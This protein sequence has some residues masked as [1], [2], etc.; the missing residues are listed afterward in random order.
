MPKIK[1]KGILT[2]RLKITKNGKILRRQGFRRHLKASK[3]SKRLH[4]LKKTIEL[5]G[6]YAK[7]I[8]KSTGTK[9]K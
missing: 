5:I 4:N 1:S 9:L 3:S 2:S 8:R 7:K 6:F